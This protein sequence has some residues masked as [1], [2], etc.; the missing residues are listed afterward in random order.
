MKHFFL[1]KLIFLPQILQF[2]QIQNF[3]FLQKFIT[4]VEKILS[5]TEIDWYVCYSKIAA[6][7]E[8]EKV[9]VFFRKT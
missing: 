5:W 6:L 7:N 9:Q 3:D 4:Q 8:F 2:S 1:K